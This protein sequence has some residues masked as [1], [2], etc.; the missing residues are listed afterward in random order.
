MQPARGGG[1]LRHARLT[2]PTNRYRYGVFASAVEAAGLAT[3]WL[4][5]ETTELVVPSANGMS[6]RV[7]SLA[8]GLLIEA[9]RIDHDSAI[10]PMWSTEDWPIRTA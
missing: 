5:G 1:S 9:E 4:D 7:M 3:E 10:G 2:R 6:L 8:D